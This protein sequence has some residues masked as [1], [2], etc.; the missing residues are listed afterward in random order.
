MSTQLASKENTNADSNSPS[1][2]KV[3]HGYEPISAS[4]ALVK[5]SHKPNHGE[6]I[7]RASTAG[8]KD[9]LHYPDA[10]NASIFARSVFSEYAPSSIERQGL[11]S[12]GRRVSSPRESQKTVGRQAF[13]RAC[14][15]MSIAVPIDIDDDVTNM[16]GSSLAKLV[17]VVKKKDEA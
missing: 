3:N 13:V 2:K 16:H 5:D 10:E 14:R 4:T 12:R 9:S 1:L 6:E 7:E 11:L 8:R 15:V 17:R